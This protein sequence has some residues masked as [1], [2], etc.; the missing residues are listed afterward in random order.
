LHLPD[1]ELDI[2]LAHVAASDR[3][4]A[5]KSLID[6]DLLTRGFDVKDLLVDGTSLRTSPD[7]DRHYALGIVR[8]LGL[9]PPATILAPIDEEPLPFDALGLED[10]AADTPPH[11]SRATP[12]TVMAVLARR[13][14]EQIPHNRLP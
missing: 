14:Y 13:S 2:Y 1:H 11:R 9:R 7:G 12:C 5:I 4:V 3:E 8:L 6:R 10:D